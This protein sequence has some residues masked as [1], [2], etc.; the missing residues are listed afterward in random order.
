MH[1][2]A[3]YPM[4]RVKGSIITETALFVDID[5]ERPCI[6]LELIIIQFS[7]ELVYHEDTLSS[8]R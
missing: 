6:G 5:S 2:L 7:G 1:Y 3:L 4:Q 8:T